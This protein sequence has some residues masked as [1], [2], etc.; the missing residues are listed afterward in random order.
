MKF[1]QLLILGATILHL[2]VTAQKKDS[3]FSFLYN[4]V[5]SGTNPEQLEYIIHKM[6]AVGN[7]G[8]DQMN[9]DLISYSKAHVAE[10]YA[11]SGNST[12]ATFWIDQVSDSAWK[13]SAALS[14]VEAL[15]EVNKIADAEKLLQP[16]LN[17]ALDNPPRDR[18][19]MKLVNR[20]PKA[21]FRF[22]YGIILY[23][24]GEYSKALNYLDPS[25]GIAQE[26]N[27][28]EYYPLL[29]IAV[30]RNEEAVA[31]IKI[32][33]NGKGDASDDFMKTASQLFKKYYHNSTSFQQFSDSVA[34]VK[35]Q[36]A[37]KKMS[38]YKVNQ[39]ASDFSITDVRGKTISLASLKGKTVIM[40]FWAT[41]C[42]PC[43]G[44]FPGM[45]RAVNY[46]KKD[47]NVVFMFIH[48]SERSET[49][50]EDAISLLTNRHYTF[51]LF[52]DLKTPATNKNPLLVAFEVKALP[53]KFVIDKNGII[54]FRN[55]GYVSE[56]EAVD[57]IRAMVDMANKSK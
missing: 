16:F 28:R 52:M 20:V 6:E 10:L 35:G 22:K 45:Q 7:E 30:G 31:A 46:Y 27:N 38:A 51:D 32:V 13:E 56:Y 44:S 8:N 47:T 15:M 14:S 39:P 43:V 36:T 53:T 3:S 5:K 33:M 37:E 11:H 54:K 50:T 34:L 26:P 55:S 12:R 4:V 48:T 40:D 42:V 23:K 25:N 29:L 41:W 2:S 17:A 21:L 57:E 19:N 18:N 9:V 49:A 24:K 1:L